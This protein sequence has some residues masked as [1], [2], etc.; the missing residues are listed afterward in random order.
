MPNVV[1]NLLQKNLDV[2]LE[3]G[4]I[5]AGKTNITRWEVVLKDIFILGFWII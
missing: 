1:I 5:V 3:E 2:A 4:E